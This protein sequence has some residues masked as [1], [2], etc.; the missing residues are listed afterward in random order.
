[1]CDMYSIRGESPP[2]D[3]LNVAEHVD[4]MDRIW[5][6][7]LDSD[8]LNKEYVCDIGSIRASRFMAIS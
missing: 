5:G 6:E 8:F 2:G 4:D 3:F 1:M 7:S